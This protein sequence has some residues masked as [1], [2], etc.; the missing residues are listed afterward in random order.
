MVKKRPRPLKD[1]IPCLK[2]FFYTNFSW[3]K[4]VDTTLSASLHP[5][6]YE[7]YMFTPG[8]LKEGINLR[9]SD[10]RD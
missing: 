2:K 6:V 5:R 1:E 7:H 8:K 9:I 10:V 3:W 4:P